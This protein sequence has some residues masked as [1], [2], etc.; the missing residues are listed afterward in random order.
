LFQI[1]LESIS[2]VKTQ[3][4]ILPEPFKQYVIEA[5][6]DHQLKLRIIADFISSLTE[7]QA[8]FMHKRLIGLEPGSIRELIV[9]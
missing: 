7:Q 5:G 9:R 3:A 8:L 1:I 2:D 4:A 6:N